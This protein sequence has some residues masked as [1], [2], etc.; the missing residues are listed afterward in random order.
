MVGQVPEKQQFAQKRDGGG[1]DRR[2]AAAVPRPAGTRTGAH[3]VSAE[4]PRTKCARLRGCSPEGTSISP[5]LK[6]GPVT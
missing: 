5:T 3:A 1:R 4:R 2:G 6:K